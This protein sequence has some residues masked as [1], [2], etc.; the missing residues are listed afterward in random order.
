MQWQGHKGYASAP[1]NSEAAVVE[2][3][4]AKLGTLLYLAIYYP[5]LQEVGC[6]VW[7]SYIFF[8]EKYAEI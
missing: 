1:A 7:Y 4:Q 8:D 2:V 5:F 3:F 6:I